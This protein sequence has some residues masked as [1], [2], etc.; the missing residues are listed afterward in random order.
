MFKLVIQDDE[1]KTTV[2]PLIRD[3]IT[4][5]RKEGNTI[6][7]TERNVSRRHARIVRM[8][9]TVAIED[10][11]SYNGVR[12]NGTRIAQRTALTISDR[13]QIG[14]YLIELKAEGAEVGPTDDGKTQPIERLDP[15]MLA[16]R[17]GSG[18][19]TPVMVGSP[20]ATMVAL[21][22]TDPNQQAARIAAAAGMP[23]PM[24][25]AAVPAPS[26]FARLVILS[27]NFAGQEFE[28]T[29]PQMIIGRTDD[30]DIVVNHRSIS[31]NHAKIVR[32]ADTG[33]Y[34]ISDLASSN[35][36]RVN[37]E[38]YGKVEL[39]RGDTIDLGHVRMRFVEPGEDFLFG[40]DAQA[41]DVPTGGSKK[42]LIIALVGLVAVGGIVVAVMAGGGSKGSS[43]GS[44]VASASGGTGA[45]TGTGTASAVAPG[46]A[47]A[48]Q[49][50][51]AAADAM[52][53]GSATGTGGGSQ[54]AVVEPGSGSGTASGA[55][56]GTEPPANDAAAKKLEE[57]KGLRDKDD[58][59]GLAACASDLAKL[60]PNSADAKDLG[61]LAKKEVASSLVFDDLKS[62]MGKKDFGSVKQY[63]D[64]LPDDSVYKDKARALCDK[65]KD[66]FIAEMTAR[67][68]ALA[69]AHKC[70]DIAKLAQQAG[71]LWPEAKDAVDGVNC[72]EPVAQ[73][74]PGGGSHNPPGG[75]SASDK[76][77]GGGS[78]SA[79]PPS[80]GG[81]PA[82]LID[83]ARA[84][85]KNSQ[86]GKALRLCEEALQAD[87]GNADAVMVC[88]LASC[89]LKNTAKAKNYIGRLNPS[90]QGMA[91]QSCL[92]NG[93]D[94]GGQ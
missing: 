30:N 23:Q 22:D 67:A 66:D 52:E 25:V 60:D 62:A 89:N 41:V 79:T 59:T 50:M 88:A 4:I 43:A 38:E 76:P 75:G 44:D 70:K 35:G 2:V 21:A 36:V 11:G 65:A 19:A 73:N 72:T 77:P 40:R 37:G 17:G 16:A 29:K 91:R 3:E 20:H 49:P 55:G 24:A 10:L 61:D 14:D 34:T 8:N 84:A 18:V 15:A 94:P 46:P 83:D 85:A 27:S 45:G 6:R 42:G 26:G 74:P 51:V 53:S 81:N 71:K 28:L 54:V 90:R 78:S 32:E 87:R 48:A 92:R 64:K 80:G 1:G 68:H 31:R 58:W 57:C 47:D 82:Q 5:G 69:N 7:L 56:T 63:C 12:V 33:R 39:R 86:W 9:G 13:V 93:I